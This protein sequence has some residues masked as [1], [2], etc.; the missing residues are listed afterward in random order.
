MNDFEKARLKYKPDEIKCLFLAEAP[1]ALDS[2]RFFYFEDVMKADWLFLE[3]IRAL[4]PETNDIEAR[5]V[6]AKKAH[7]LSA[8]KKLGFYLEDASLFPMP[9]EPTKSQ[10]RNLLLSQLP[11]LLHRLAPHIQQKTP[12]ILISAPVF[13]VC[14]TPLKTAGFNILNDYPIP[15]P[16][17]FQ[18][19]YREGIS[20]SLLLLHKNK[21]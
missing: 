16:Q 14:Y 8:F 1:P 5:L 10:K 3:T 15:F 21:R 20:K 12:V 13:K 11:N 7:Y 4:F 2:K 6:R 19:L 9:P 18:S 17:G